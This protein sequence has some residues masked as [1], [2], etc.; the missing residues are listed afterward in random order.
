MTNEYRAYLPI[1]VATLLR[2]KKFASPQLPPWHPLPLPSM[3]PS[4]RR[5][6]AKVEP[7]LVDLPLR[8]VRSTV[9]ERAQRVGARFTV[10]PHLPTIIRTAAPYTVPHPPQIPI[11]TAEQFT[12]HHRP[13]IQTRTAAPFTALL[14][15]LGPA[16]CTAL[17]V[18][19]NERFV[20]MLDK[21]VLSASFK[22]FR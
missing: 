21:P 5:Q 14:H 3:P 15:P 6:K 12:V 8:V 2:S 11:R 22:L 10:L 7:S 13:Q 4:H 20:D 1:V 19:A 16:P 9:L 18:Q 17:V